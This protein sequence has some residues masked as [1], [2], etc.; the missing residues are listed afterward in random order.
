MNERT[1]QCWQTTPCCLAAVAPFR[2]I[3]YW[4]ALLSTCEGEKRSNNLGRYFESSE[5]VWNQSSLCGRLLQTSANLKPSQKPAFKVR[6]SLGATLKKSESIVNGG[7]AWRTVSHRVGVALKRL[8]KRLSH[9]FRSLHGRVPFSSLAG[10]PSLPEDI[11]RFHT[12]VLVARAHNRYPQRV[13]RHCDSPA[14]TNRHKPSET[15][16]GGQFDSCEKNKQDKPLRY[17]EQQNASSTN[18]VRLARLLLKQE[19][20]MA[21]PL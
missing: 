12:A 2:N 6:H 16:R 1:D 21:E 13:A 9:T 7:Q 11:V 4:G 19:V 15:N 20:K 17:A 3:P 8:R 14:E 5:S 18:N 10:G